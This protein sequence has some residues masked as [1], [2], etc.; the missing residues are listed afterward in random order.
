MF[1][2]IFDNIHWIFS[3]IGVWVIQSILKRRENHKPSSPQEI[4][5]PSHH[6]LSPN[7]VNECSAPQTE[8]EK[9]TSRFCTVLE[10]MNE[11][12]GNAKFTLPQLAQVMGLEK[13]SDLENVM[14][15][16]V[17]PNFAFIEHFCECFGVNPRWLKEGVAS[18]FSNDDSTK[19]DPLW[20]LDE[21]KA[22]NPQGIFFIR[23]K[24]DSAPAF[25]L[26]K[27]SDFKY[28]ILRRSWHI[29]GDVGAGG[30]SQLVG[31]Y[32]LIKKLCRG[33]DF[34]SR[35]G[36]LILE[37]H[38]FEALRTGQIFP[39][40]YILHRHENPWWDD[41]IDIHHKYPIAENYRHW[42]GQSFIDAQD[43]IKWKLADSIS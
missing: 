25:I 17:E 30:Q 42:Y 4:A 36:G 21:I 34:G 40:K 10:L 32:K 1:D 39:G 18:P 5:S 12:R 28:K 20:Y 19:G 33:M 29:S 6:E 43:I 13:I 38:E 27:L 11:G 9:L 2:F 15:G 26:L 3:G 23:E 41:L 22:L 7:I 24:S 14:T 31:F 16:K 8:E 35:C 37:H